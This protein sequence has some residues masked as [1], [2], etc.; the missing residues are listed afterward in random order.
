MELPKELYEK[1][2]SLCQKAEQF[3]DDNQ[4]LK[5]EETFLEALQLVPEPKEDW[6][7]TAYIQ[8]AL[9]DVKFGEGLIE[10]ANDYFQ[11]AYNHGAYLDNPF[12]NLRLGQCAFELGNE[13]RARNFL[14]SAYA[15]A[16]EDIFEG[17]EDTFKIIKDLV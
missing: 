13:D 5:A 16:G 8:V 11:K 14:I 9:G 12:L 10:E 2:D 4:P 7:A 1:I 3:L 17:A 6:D 15:I